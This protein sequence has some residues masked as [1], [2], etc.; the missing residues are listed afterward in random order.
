MADKDTV[1]KQPGLVTRI[2]TNTAWVIVT[3]ILNMALGV[4]AV[5]YLARYLGTEGFGKYSFIFAYLSFFTVLSDFGTGAILVREA[6]RDA[7]AARKLLGNSIIMRL[8]FP[9]L[10]I[11]L[12]YLIILPLKSSAEMRSLVLVASLGFLFSFSAVYK[13]IF[14]VSLKMAYPNLLDTAGNVIKLALFLLVILKGGTLFDFILVSAV[15]VL[16]AVVALMYFSDKI[17]TPRF[18]IDFALW[19]RLLKESWP[20]ALSGV[21][22]LIY[23]RVD[24][25]MLSL[26][27]GDE[28]VGYYSAAYR[29]TELFTVIPM[30][31]SLSLLPLM[32]RFF[33]SENE[34]AKTYY[35]QGMKYMMLL[36][37]PLATGIMMLSSKIIP[38]IYGR[39]FTLAIPAL[40][41]L[42]WAEALI[43]M[44]IILANALVAVRKQWVVICN[45]SIGMVL[46]IILN[47]IF[48]PSFGFVG[49]ASTTV[50]TELTTFLLGVYMM[51]KY[52]FPA[53]ISKLFV[54]VAFACSLMGFYIFFFN[55]LT[56]ALLII[57]AAVIFIAAAFALK[58]MN[59]EDIRLMQSILRNSMKMKAGAVRLSP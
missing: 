37:L 10:T 36:A 23:L 51:S 28:A 16:P 1:E 38:P 35:Q 24:T 54:K 5:M 46:N 26:M 6:S 18:D 14:Q 50:A 52:Q 29:L 17:I 39:Q 41:V 12:A 49:A 59:K 44:N 20:L 34:R 53:N 8:L 43:F 56:I 21:F 45:T 57:T 27:K 30:A 2:A 9:L 15:Y 11:A 47:F 4:L 58:I 13:V 3:H 48:I 19:K 55:G 40:S 7:E 42:A 31:F 32:S 25:V 22:I 33:G